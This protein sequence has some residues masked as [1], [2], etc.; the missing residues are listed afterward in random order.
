V[1]K[2]KPHV[3]EKIGGENRFYIG[4]INNDTKL[5]AKAVREIGV[6]KTRSIG[7]SNDIVNLVEYPFSQI[8]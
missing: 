4:G 3:E 8:G 1:V 7:F 2:S 5:L 6:K